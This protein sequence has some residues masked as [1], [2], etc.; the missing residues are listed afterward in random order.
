[1]YQNKKKK[2]IHIGILVAII[3]I[4]I[5]SCVMAMIFY[6]IEGEKKMP[7]NISKISVVSSVEGVDKKVEGYINSK[8]INQNND[9]YIYI[10]KNEN[11]KDTEVIDSIVI[12]NFKINKVTANGEYAIYKPTGSDV[13]IFEDLEENKV[14]EIIYTG[15]LQS[16]IKNMKIS[17]QGGI[18]ALRYTNLNVS[19]Y[20]SN[21]LNELT[22]L[23]L[24]SLTNVDEE[25]LKASITFDLT[26]NLASDT[27]FTTTIMVDVP[28]SGIVETGLTTEESVNIE[29]IVFKRVEK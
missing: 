28:I 3:A 15:D 10:E 7:F 29:N 17:N 22:N 4:L 1:M 16:D 24:L 19:E 25:D 18:I 2:I 11:Y 13:D 5:F 20:L 21:D 8:D 14:N 27:S 9:I 26:I 6:E 12:N 23:D